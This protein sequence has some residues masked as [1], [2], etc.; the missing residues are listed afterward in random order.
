MLQRDDQ[1]P[2]GANLK[3]EPSGSDFN[4]IS[5]N[6]RA[7]LLLVLTSGAACRNRR[8]TTSSVHQIYCPY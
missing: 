3:H 2:L 5:E 6:A 1:V 7:A 8:D 4:R